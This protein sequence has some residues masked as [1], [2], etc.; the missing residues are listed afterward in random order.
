MTCI[1]KELE[2]ESEITGR[3]LDRVPDDK[4]TWKPHAKSMTLGQL[5]LHIASIPSSILPLQSLSSPSHVSAAGSFGFSSH[6]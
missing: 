2:Q 1:I 4:L 6:R 3:V 5:A